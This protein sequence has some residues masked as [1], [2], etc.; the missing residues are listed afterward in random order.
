MPVICLHPSSNIQILM[1]NSRVKKSFEEIKW[2]ERVLKIQSR[3]T[4]WVLTSWSNSIRFPDALMK[5]NQRGQKRFIYADD[6]QSTKPTS[7]VNK[8]YAALFS[9]WK[10]IQEPNKGQH[11][12][13]TEWL[14]MCKYV[15][16]TAFN[17]ARGL[18]TLS[19]VCRDT[20]CKQRDKR[21]QFINKSI[22]ACTWNWHLHESILSYC[23]F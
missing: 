10:N 9:Q 1:W 11:V 6:L 22:P 5:P 4:S 8:N 14:K 19:Y 13:S 3:V 21:E 12:V 18:F 15:F 16:L 7:L 17:R 2:F 20:H 23:P